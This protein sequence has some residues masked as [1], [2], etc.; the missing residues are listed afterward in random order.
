MNHN[1]LKAIGV[2]HPALEEI[3]QISNSLGF[4]SKLTGAGGG[5]YVL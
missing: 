5:G 3:F 1:L 2:S 4:G